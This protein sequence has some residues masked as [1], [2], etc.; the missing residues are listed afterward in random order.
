MSLSLLIP[1]AS[2]P[3]SLDALKAHLRVDTT[4]EDTLI[5]SL[6]V[7]ARQTIEARLGIAFIN[8]RWRLALTPPLGQ[9]VDLPIGPVSGIDELTDSSGIVAPTLYLAKLGR[10]GQVTL[11]AGIEGNVSIE[12][13]V[14]Y[15]DAASVPEDLKLAVKIL[16][17]HYFENREAAGTD[18]FFAPPQ[19]LETLL[20]PW[21][22]VRI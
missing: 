12:F 19:G 21:R 9:C 17:A 11:G 22:R 18:R 15:A 6:G 3:V 7:A 10:H 4:T 8:Q 14:G 5:A 20:N 13:T 2:E 1:P 16:T